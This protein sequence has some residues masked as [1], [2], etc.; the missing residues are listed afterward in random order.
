M[1]YAIEATDLRKSFKGHQ[2][3]DGLH[4]RVEQGELFALLGPNGA[5]KTTTV[6]ILSTLLKP[7][8]GTARVAG[9][10]AAKNAGEV[11]RRISVTGQFAALD[12]GLSGLQNMML[13]ARL[14]GYSAREA[15]SIAERLVHAFGLEEAKN[16]TVQHYS[17]GMRR[18]LDIAA[19][20]VSRPEVLF[21]DEP[22]TGLD[23]ESRLGI[24]ESIRS[25][26]KRGTTVLLTTQYLEEADRLADR[27]A[28]MDGGK[29][30]AEGTPTALKAS[31][32]GKTLKIRLENPSGLERVRRLLADHL[33]LAAHPGDDPHDV[34][35]PVTDAGL[36]GQAIHLLSSHNVALNDFGLDEPSLDEVFLSLTASRRSEEAFA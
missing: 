13:I 3:V 24:W 22:T 9:Y 8:G 16:R 35:I 34:R 17:G 4:L 5:G 14:Q 28:V 19:G 2:A 31:I 15:R 36:A 23:P 21:L 32:G 11:R 27:V 12:E 6:N 1:P 25:L 18:R 30:V 29:I 10:D 26:L 20:I 7:D 33:K